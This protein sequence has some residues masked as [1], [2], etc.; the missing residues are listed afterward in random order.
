VKI[1]FFDIETTGKANFKAPPEAEYQPRI[2][3]LGALL[4]DENA[5]DISAVN[6][7][8]KPISDIPSEASSIHGITTEF[9][10]SH[11]VKLYHVLQ[12]YWGLVS[13]ADLI[14]AHNIDYDSFVIEGETRR[15][16]ADGQDKPGFCTMKAMT[17]VCK[18]PG[19]YGDFKWPKLAE[20]YRHAFGKDFDGAHD[21]MSDIRATKEVYFWLKTQPTQ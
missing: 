6:L 19:N 7:F 13:A 20:A 4:C 18:I 8:V 16:D 21:A 2:V 9:A 1:L 17:P 3:Q 15:V 5:T 12:V 10:Q 14:V 11:G